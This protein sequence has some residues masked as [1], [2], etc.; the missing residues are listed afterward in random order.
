MQDYKSLL[1]TTVMIR[2]TLVNTLTDA[3]FLASCHSLK[4][5]KGTES[6]VVNVVA[7]L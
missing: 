7:G 4:S 3:Q 1:K 2:A 6:C 5:D